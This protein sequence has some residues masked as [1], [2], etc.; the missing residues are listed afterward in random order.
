MRNRLLLLAC[1]ALAAMGALAQSIQPMQ[2]KPGIVAAAQIDRAAILE[3]QNKKLRA[4]NAEL[5][6]ELESY[7]A[8]GGSQVH[9]Y[10]SDDAKTSHNT[11][12]AEQDCGKSGYMC[13]P[14][15]GQCRTSCQTS[16]MCAGGF[17]CDTSTSQ[18]VYTAG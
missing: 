5:K 9:A 2:L 8:K 15:G 17:T 12:G 1:L 7:R 6:A 10:C 11:A 14:V 16:D 4:E 18:C 3:E 13:E